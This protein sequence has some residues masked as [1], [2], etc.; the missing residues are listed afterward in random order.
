M[1]LSPE[2]KLK[3]LLDTPD[4]VYTESERESL[5]GLHDAQQASPGATK[6]HDEAKKALWKYR[7]ATSVGEIGDD[8][9]RLCSALGTAIEVFEHEY[10]DAQAV[11]TLD[12]IGRILKG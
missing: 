9:R 6:E 8:R 3:R 12:E 10:G 5:G 2:Q 1:I 4:H 11:V 7:V